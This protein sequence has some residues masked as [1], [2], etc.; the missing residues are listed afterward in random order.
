M[1]LHVHAYKLLTLK[2]LQ[3]LCFFVGTEGR[4]SSKVSLLVSP[5]WTS[6]ERPVDDGDCPYFSDPQAEVPWILLAG[7]WPMEFLRGPSSIAKLN[8]PICG[9]G[10]SSNS[11]NHSVDLVLACAQ[12]LKWA[13]GT[14]TE[15]ILTQ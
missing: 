3:I 10:E 9:L 6:W 5:T 2:P 11:M 8:K 1:C 4:V 7:S 14:T 13:L 12:S 15:L